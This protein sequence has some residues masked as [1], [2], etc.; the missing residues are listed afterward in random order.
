MTVTTLV[1]SQE[2]LEEGFELDIRLN[3]APQDAAEFNGPEGR[4]HTVLDCTHPTT[5]VLP[6]GPC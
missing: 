1:P 2:T 5:T 6:T 3:S 4:L